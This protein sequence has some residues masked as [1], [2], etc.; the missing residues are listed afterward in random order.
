MAGQPF[1]FLDR[2]GTLLHDPG[3]LHKVEDYQPI[4]G[5]I[6]ALREL[7]QAG[8]ALAIATNQSGIGRGYFSEPDFQRFQAHLT[9]DFA[10]QGVRFAATLFCPHLPDANCGCRKPAPGMLERAQPELEVDLERSWMVGDKPEDMEFARRAG[11]DR[12]MWRPSIRL[13]V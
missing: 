10:A 2:D 11:K 5:V 7:I 13:P 9:Q 12:T 8:F 4:A 6:E 1:V 3:Y